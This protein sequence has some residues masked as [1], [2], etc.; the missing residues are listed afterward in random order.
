MGPPSKTPAVSARWY[1]IALAAGL[2]IG[3]LVIVIVQLVER[4]TGTPAEGLGAGWRNDPKAAAFLVILAILAGI[5]LLAFLILLVTRLPKPTTARAVEAQ[6]APVA[7]PIG[8]R[9]LGLALLAIAILL[10]GWLYLPP[11]QQYELMLRLIYPASFAVGLVLLFDKATR[12]WN[13][14]SAKANAREWLY[15]DALLLLL[16]LGFVNLSRS[17]A[18]ESYRAFFWDVAHVALF[19]FAFWLV[20][21]KLTRYRFLAA[22]VYL[23]LLPLL[24]LI[25]RAVQ[26]IPQSGSWSET[27]WPFFFLALI[28]ALLEIIALAAAHDVENRALSVL[29]DVIF[30]VLYAILL[31]VAIPKA[32]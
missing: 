21:R 7:A 17:A 9:V 2:L 14:K 27:I 29:K 19:F 12:G 28:A 31:I 24:L 26:G 32:G 11:A 10:M 20:D 1:E 3:L 16:L 18:A 13:P 4:V 5:G 30:M 8:M 6:T 25:W 23:L 15:C 22:Q